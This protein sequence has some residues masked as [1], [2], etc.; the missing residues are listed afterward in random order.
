MIYR[1]NN[2]KFNKIIF[3]GGDYVLK[4]TQIKEL[5]KLGYNNIQDRDK[6]ISSLMLKTNK[7]KYILNEINKLLDNEFKN[8]LVIFLINTDKKEI[9]RRINLRKTKLD[10]WDKDALYYNNLYK[11]IGNKIN[12]NNF[13]IV[14]NTNKSQE[15]TLNEIINIFNKT[16]VV[17]NGS[18]EK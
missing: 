6:R 13:F 4:T 8:N 1:M 3:E 2:M 11:I 18:K 16:G 7:E 17:K 10:E 9:N 12:R 14:D 15:E 5:N